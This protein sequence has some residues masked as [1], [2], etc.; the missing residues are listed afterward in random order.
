MNFGDVELKNL[1]ILYR[2]IEIKIFNTI[3]GYQY[4]FNLNWLDEKVNLIKY[5][6]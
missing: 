6:E 3:I 5:T 1:Y 4:L 2:K